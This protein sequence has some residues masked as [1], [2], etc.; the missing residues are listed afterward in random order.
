MEELAR[1]GMTMVVVTH[2]I[3]FAKRVA[4]RVIMMDEGEIIEDAAPDE[5]FDRP[6]HERT[7]RFLEAVH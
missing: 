2:E 4:D 3:G 1:E 5:F 6:G 7:R